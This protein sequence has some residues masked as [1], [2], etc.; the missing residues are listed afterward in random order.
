MAKKLSKVLS[1]VAAR[2]VRRIPFARED[3]ESSWRALSALGLN[4]QP[5]HVAQMYADIMDAADVTPAPTIGASTPSM[6]TLIQFLQEWMPGWVHTVSAARKIDQLVGITTVG[7]FE[8]EEVVQG[9][10]EP[11]AEAEPY[12]DYTNIPLSDYNPTV[13]GRTIVRFE[14]GLKVGFLEDLR[15]GRMRINTAG[16]KRNAASQSLEIARNNVGFYG[17]NDG[18]NR[19][20]GFLNDPN[21]ASALTLPNGVAGT[22]TWPTKT[23]LEIMA[24]IRLMAATLQ[25]NTQ[26][27]VDPATVPIVLALPTSKRQYINVP[28]DLGFSVAKYLA[29]NYPNWRIESAPQLQNAVGGVDVA[30]LYAESMDDDSTDSGS[31]WLQAVPSKFQTLGVEKRAKS[32]VEDY[33]NATAGVFLKRPFLVLRFV[34]L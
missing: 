18:A 16:E 19:T 6:P 10:M 27:T 23:P 26:D 24:D 22:A 13:E 9:F 29:E 31:T 3:V 2:D 1:H 7:S 21:L 17:Y 12:G 32:Y 4:L 34:G 30:Y 25:N 28:T 33:A 5:N 8:Q 20:Y 11:L 14:K 15:A